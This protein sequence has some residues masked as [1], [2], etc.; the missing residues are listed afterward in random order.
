MRFTV[1]GIP[2]LNGGKDV[3]YGAGISYQFIPDTQILKICHKDE[4]HHL[5]HMECKGFLQ[6]HIGG[7]IECLEKAM[8][9]HALL[10]S[11]D[12]TNRI[13][14]VIS[15]EKLPSLLHH[16][17][18]VARD[19]YALHL[20]QFEEFS[21]VL[22]REYNLKCAYIKYIHGSSF[23]VEN[24]YEGHFKARIK[25]HNNDRATVR[26]CVLHHLLQN[27]AD[28]IMMDIV[29]KAY[30]NNQRDEAHLLMK[31]SSR[32]GTMGRILDA[33]YI[34]AEQMNVAVAKVRGRG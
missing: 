14:D 6:E 10:L 24:E 30:A 21:E 9:I 27:M 8:Q 18:G 32:L 2:S 22:R 17:V 25:T 34:P 1:D 16:T 23:M 3:I 13:V 5:L 15:I 11:S 33:G 29:S 4:N 20:N 19:S 7:Y 31:L 28:S 26:S 12:A